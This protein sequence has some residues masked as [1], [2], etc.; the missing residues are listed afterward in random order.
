MTNK[1]YWC[2]KTNLIDIL[3]QIWGLQASP[4]FNSPA[5]EELYNLYKKGRSA[6]DEKV[7]DSV[8][9]LQPY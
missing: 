3:T 2:P 4:N 1:E 8:K 5:S 7:K 9:S 6:Y